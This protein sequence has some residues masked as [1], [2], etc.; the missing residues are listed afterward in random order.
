MFPCLE[1]VTWESSYITQEP[2]YQNT[3]ER[4]ELDIFVDTVKNYRWHTIVELKT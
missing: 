4:P 1:P 3:T 2:I